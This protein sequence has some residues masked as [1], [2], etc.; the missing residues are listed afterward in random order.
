MTVL[1]HGAIE[2]SRV[3]IGCAYL[4]EGIWPFSDERI[5]RAALEAGARHFDVAPLYGLGTAE[6]VLGRALRGRRAEVTIASKVGLPRPRVARAHLIA[7]SVAS[8]L[9]NFL[10]R[11]G[12][13]PPSAAGTPGSGGHF[14]LAYVQQSLSESLAHLE[15]DYLDI[16]LLHEVT[17]GD[18]GD[19]LL[20]FITGRRAAGVTRAIGLATSRAESERIVAAFPGVFDVVQ[21]SW[22]ILDGPLSRAATDPFLIVHRSLMGA[23]RPL[24]DW[25]AADQAACARMSQAAGLDLSDTESLASVLIASAQAVNP[26]GIGLIASHRVARTIRNVHAA[27]DSR[28]QAAALRLLEALESERHAAANG[29]PASG[30][31]VP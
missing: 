17:L 29:G 23:F 1:P 19:E 20:T 7:R 13:V 16:W 24:A 22:N 25:F 30:V 26:G 27:L 4:A 6:K 11:R 8:P 14:D 28:M 3:G 10:R 18:I 2:T 31:P 15:T 5:V 21:Y 9:R 12:P